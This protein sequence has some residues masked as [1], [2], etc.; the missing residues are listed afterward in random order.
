[1]TT[2]CR[3]CLV[4]TGIKGNLL[5]SIGAAGRNRHL[6]REMA[7]SRLLPQDPISLSQLQLF[8]YNYFWKGWA[9]FCHTLLCPFLS[10]PTPHCPDKALAL[11]NGEVL[12]FSPA[13]CCHQKSFIILLLHSPF[14]TCLSL[15]DPLLL[16]VCLV[17]L[18]HQC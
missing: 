14:F 1:M 18:L 13:F 7:V 10:L 17:F 12:C 3:T 15:R 8:G 6:A 5:K 9:P 2:I 11:L 16:A 4:S